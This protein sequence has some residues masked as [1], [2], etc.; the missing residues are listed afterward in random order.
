M[1]RPAMTHLTGATC[2]GAQ[3]RHTNAKELAALF[4]CE[5]ASHTVCMRCIKALEKPAPAPA[6]TPVYKARW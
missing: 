6:P 2:K 3:I 4:N 5:Y 1:N